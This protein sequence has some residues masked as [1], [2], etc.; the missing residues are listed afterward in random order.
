[1]DSYCQTTHMNCARIMVT[2]RGDVQGEYLY[3]RIKKKAQELNVLGWM[4]NHK[5]DSVKACLEGE[6]KNVDALFHWLFQEPGGNLVRSVECMAANYTGEFK[7]FSFLAS[8][9][10]ESSDPIVL[11]GSGNYNY[12]R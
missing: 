8:G 12:A 7:D 3:G 9:T 11:V 2:I 4:M 1:M 10:A 5:V 6:K